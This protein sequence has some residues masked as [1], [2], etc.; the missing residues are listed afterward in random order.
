MQMQDLAL[1]RQEIVFDV[2]AIHGLQMT[3]QTAVEISSAISAVSLPRP[4]WRAAS[5][6]APDD[7]ACRLVPLRDARIQIPAVVI[8]AR[9]EAMS[10]AISCATFFSIGVK[11]TTTSATCTP[12]LSM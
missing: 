3:A 9:L 7:F 6:G 4:R 2:E 1:A 8:E 12:V 11:P 10:A 5:P